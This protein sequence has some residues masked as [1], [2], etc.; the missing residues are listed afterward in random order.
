MPKTIEG[1]AVVSSTDSC[2]DH[3]LI[4]FSDDKDEAQFALED[5]MQIADNARM[6]K[7]TLTLHE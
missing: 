6:V 7:A 4:Q 5:A 3:S 1:F 2:D